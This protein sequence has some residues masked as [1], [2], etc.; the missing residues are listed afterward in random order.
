MYLTRAQEWKGKQENCP[1]L[2][3]R[4]QAI[5][6]S[7]LKSEEAQPEKSQAVKAVSLLISETVASKFQSWAKQIITLH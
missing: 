5:P 1:C 7:T 2:A 3:L 4:K 6:W